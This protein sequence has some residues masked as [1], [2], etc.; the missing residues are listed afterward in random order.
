MSFETAVTGRPSAD[1]V[2]AA[3]FAIRYVK[4][5]SGSN[6]AKNVFQDHPESAPSPEI[7]DLAKLLVQAVE[8]EFG[9]PSRDIQGEQLTQAL[10]ALS[11]LALA[12]QDSAS[13]AEVEAAL[14]VMDEFEERL[15]AAE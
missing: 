6:H 5:A 12:R 4:Q 14:A 15:A 3:Y 9:R 10:H 11:S 1:V 7:V 13:P 8:R 2:A